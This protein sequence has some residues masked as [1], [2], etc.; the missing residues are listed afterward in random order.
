MHSHTRV[1]THTHTHT[2]TQTALT[3]EMADPSWD[4][5][6]SE[7]P[8]LYEVPHKTMRVASTRP[9]I[10]FVACLQGNHVTLKIHVTRVNLIVCSNHVTLM[11]H[12][13]RANL[14]GGVL[15]F[16]NQYQLFRHVRGGNY[17]AT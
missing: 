17:V 5:A 10:P 13:T 3:A 12:V 14:I 6:A 8:P 16:C 1:H 9:S 15:L 11:I 4:A 7:C 2:H